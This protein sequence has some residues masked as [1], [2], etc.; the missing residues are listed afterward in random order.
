MKLNPVHTITWHHIVCKHADAVACSA[1]HKTRSGSNHCRHSSARHTWRHVK[2]WQPDGLETK[3]LEI[4]GKM[5]RDRETG[6][7][8]GNS[9]IVHIH[10]SAWL[11]CYATHNFYITLPVYL[12]CRQ[13]TRVL[14]HISPIHCSHRIRHTRCDTRQANRHQ[15]PIDTMFRRCYCN[16]NRSLDTISHKEVCVLQEQ[17]CNAEGT[18]HGSEKRINIPTTLSQNLHTVNG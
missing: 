9:L 10:K 17:T 7:G 5:K 11:T 8:W 13:Q 6:N 3:S 14:V 18:C 2:G 1:G 15:V 4:V 12:C 16:E